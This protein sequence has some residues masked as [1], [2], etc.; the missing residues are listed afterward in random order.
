MSTR[1]L[2]AVKRTLTQMENEKTFTDDGQISGYAQE[3]VQQ[4]QQAGIIG[5][6][7]DGSFG[8]QQSHR[9]EAAKIICGMM[10]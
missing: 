10:N 2:A 3:S 8:P 6:Y 4:M 1:A 9:A 5:G 7:A